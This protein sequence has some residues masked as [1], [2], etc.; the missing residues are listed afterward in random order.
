MYY[1]KCIFFQNIG[2]SFSEK[3][4]QIRRKQGQYKKEHHLQTTVLNS[5][6]SKHFAIESFWKVNIGDFS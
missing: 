2:S 6:A 3:C 1:T 4:V 5:V